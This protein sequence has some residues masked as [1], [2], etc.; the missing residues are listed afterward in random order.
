[1]EVD[2][3]LILVLSVYVSMSLGPWVLLIGGMRYAFVAAARVLPW[4]NAP[5]PPSTARNTRNAGN[6]R[7]ARTARNM[8]YW[9]ATIL[10]ALSMLSAGAA[11][12][13]GAETPLRGM[14]DLGYPAYVVT[15]LGIWKLLGGLALLAPRFP[16][17]KEWAYAGITFNLTGAAFS[18]A[19]VSDPGTK[20][21]VPLVLLAI[22][23]A[24]WALRPESRRLPRLPE[25]RPAAASPA[26]DA[27][28]GRTSAALAA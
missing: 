17:L 27:P 1:M 2:A 25:T 13:G 19:A 6:V 18:H 16:L 24:S 8:G 10:I 20:V 15:L 26:S 11:Y 21:I 3:F 22:T 23:A 28:T 4:L 14:A 7:T 5:L 9:T 12:L